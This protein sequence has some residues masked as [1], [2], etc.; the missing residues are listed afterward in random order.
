M[1]GTPPLC[2]I[3]PKGKLS[4]LNKAHFPSVPALTFWKGPFHGW[5]LAEGFCTP[6]LMQ[7][8]RTLPAGANFSGHTAG[9]YS[10]K[11]GSILP[12][13]TTTAHTAPGNTSPAD[14][15]L[16]GC[17]YCLLCSSSVSAACCWILLL[18]LPV[19]ADLRSLSDQRLLLSFSKHHWLLWG[20][21]ISMEV[22]AANISR[23]SQGSSRRG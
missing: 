5:H 23:D 19:P 8:H 2:Q 3:R 22:M 17:N 18:P 11:T 4:K 21:C 12:G 14:P 13:V 20:G 10:P 16:C 6:Q 9:T 15:A 1:G 7:G